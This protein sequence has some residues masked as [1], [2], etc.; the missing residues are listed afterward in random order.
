MADIFKEFGTI[1]NFLR[2]VMPDP[3]APHGIA[4]VAMDTY[5]NS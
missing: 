2:R 1:E 5:I 4:V 3:H